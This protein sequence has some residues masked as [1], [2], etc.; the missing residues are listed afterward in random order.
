[1]RRLF[2]WTRVYWFFNCCFWTAIAIC[3]FRIKVLGDT[4]IAKIRVRDTYALLVYNY[5]IK[6]DIFD[7]IYLTKKDCNKLYNEYAE[8]AKTERLILKLAGVK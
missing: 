3:S 4:M 6:I 7:N 8:Q 1:M 5:R 2:N